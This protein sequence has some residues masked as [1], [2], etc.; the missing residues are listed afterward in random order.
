MLTL[1]GLCTIFRLL[2]KVLEHSTLRSICFSPQKRKIFAEAEE[3]SA[4]VKK[5]DAKK[6]E[7]TDLLKKMKLL[8]IN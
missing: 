8:L 3:R 7:S 2:R 5:N 6:D 4:P 1:Q